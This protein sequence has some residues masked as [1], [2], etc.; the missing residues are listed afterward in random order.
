[1]GRRQ[2]I[3]I[4]LA[5]AV[6]ALVVSA[7]AVLAGTISAANNGDLSFGNTTNWVIEQVSGVNSYV[8]QDVGAP[9]N[10]TLHSVTNLP[11]TTY[12]N[13]AWHTTLCDVGASGSVQ[14]KINSLNNSGGSFGVGFLGDPVYS[15]GGI[16]VSNNNDYKRGYIVEFGLGYGTFTG[17]LY[18][19]TGGWNRTELAKWTTQYSGITP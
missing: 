19:K 12:G 3:W 9:N 10:G 2:V 4:V 1:M 15:S 18:R 16:P 7:N 6:L 17:Y 11:V 13:R 14:F 8:Y 5:G